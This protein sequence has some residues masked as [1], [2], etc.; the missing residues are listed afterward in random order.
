V[1]T[2]LL[3]AGLTATLLTAGVPSA[4]HAA[5]G[6]TFEAITGSTCSMMSVNDSLPGSP[7]GGQNVWTGFVY[8][9]YVQANGVSLPSVTVSCELRV[10]G[11]TRATVL[12]PVT[13]TGVVSMGGQLQYVAQPNDVVSL[14]AH[15]TSPGATTTECRDA[16]RTDA[17]PQAALDVAQAFVYPALCAELKAFALTVDNLAQPGIVY[18]A[19]T[20]GDLYLGGA[21]VVDCL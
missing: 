21:L 2:P 18:I 19:Q 1:K 8:L 4:A 6:P 7:L 20:S 11:A 10:N 16:G 5:V 12:G 15:V 17:V 3:L 9:S 13:G 14:C